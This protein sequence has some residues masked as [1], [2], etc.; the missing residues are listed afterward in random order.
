MAKQS[1]QSVAV[2]LAVLVLCVSV[3]TQ[4]SALTWPPAPAPYMRGSP[5]ST[6]IYAPEYAP[7][8]APVYAPEYAPEYAPAYAPE[9][10]PA[11][12]PEYAPE[13]AP[14]WAPEYAPAGSPMGSPMSAP[15][16]YV[17]TPSPSVII[18]EPNSAPGP[19]SA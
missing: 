11:Y 16:P 3:T 1:R 17:F 6:P 18:T 12:T 8:Y 13:Y 15:P 9:Y 2:L 7:E 10:A 5:S 14:T 4:V 19:M